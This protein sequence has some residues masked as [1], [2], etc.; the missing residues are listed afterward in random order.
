[1][2]AF[3]PKQ[4]SEIAAAPRP[5]AKPAP[6]PAAAPV[7][8][9]KAR[10]EPPPWLDAPDQPDQDAPAPE[11]AAAA[12]EV[13]ASVPRS[14]LGD[15]WT[16]A[17][18]L[19]VERGSITA[20]VRELA[21]QAQCVAIESNASGPVWRLRVEREM[22]RGAANRDKLQAALS[23]SEGH[24][25]RIEIEAGV[26]DDS[27]ALRAN[28]ERERRQREAEQIIHNDPLVKA[29]MAQYKTARIVPGSVKPH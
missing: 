7:A 21:M 10:G 9:P 20:L 25:L 2:L 4:G 19:M 15:R 26:A 22:L 6:A 8:S 11:R 13:P 1:M 12:H 29:L 3:R 5:A 28:A 17:V 14:G 23:E 24:A 27:P 18:E 16:R